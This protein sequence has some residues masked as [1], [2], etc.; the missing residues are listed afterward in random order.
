M[1]FKAEQVDETVNGCLAGYRFT[2]TNYFT[3]HKFAKVEDGLYAM[4]CSNDGITLEEGDITLIPVSDSDAVSKKILDNMNSRN[5][6]L[7]DK[8]V[9]KKRSVEFETIYQV[10]FSDK[11]AKRHYESYILAF[12]M[13]DSDEEITEY[14]D[15]KE[16]ERSFFAYNLN[17]EDYNAICLCSP[18]SRSTKFTYNTG[19]EVYVW[20]GTQF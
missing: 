6:N 8:Y 20:F 4:L 17:G 18:N 16:R 14:A 9:T 7:V 11:I 19:D 12:A 15:V 10:E 5:M 2:E 1:D 13:K 3:R